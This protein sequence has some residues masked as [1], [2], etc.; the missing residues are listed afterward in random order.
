MSRA[1]QCLAAV[2]TVLALC[3]S[4]RSQTFTRVLVNGRTT[5]MLVA[6]SGD[7][8]VVFENGYPAPLETWGRVQPAVSEFAKTVAYDRAGMGLSDA[9]PLPRDGR[10][11]A[12]ELH[13]V[14]RRANVSP[15]YLLVGHSLGG[16]YA[17]AFTG[18]YPGEVAGVVLVDPTH[19]AEAFDFLPASPELSALPATISE[20]RAR[21]IP[22]GI[23][24][25][26][27]CAMGPSRIPFMTER[28]RASSA[29][30]RAERV[31]DSIAN[32][33]WIRGVPAGR[34]IVT[35][36]SGHN[37]PQEEPDVVINAIRDMVGGR[38]M[39]R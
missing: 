34:L 3:L 22:A 29:R 10:R 17:R 11:I 14:L 25:T 4:T 21:P 16:L 23:P 38:H 1:L 15:P 6:G 7:V 9:G 5:R 28:M 24:V 8:T 19:E 2:L 32:E 31:A 35:Y 30:R 39:A 13:D 12:S 36:G 37:V 20:I 27:I 33:A 26:L 18:E